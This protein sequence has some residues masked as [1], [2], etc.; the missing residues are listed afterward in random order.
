MKKMSYFGKTIFLTVLLT[1]ILNLALKTDSSYFLVGVLFL[2]V[3]FFS[4]MSVG[5]QSFMLARL[6]FLFVNGAILFVL[7]SQSSISDNLFLEISSM[8]I[9][10]VFLAMGRFSSL[11]KMLP[12]MSR[13]DYGKIAPKYRSRR[14]IILSFLYVTAFVWYANAFIVYSLWGYSFSAALILVFLVTFLLTSFTMK[15]YSASGKERKSAAP[16]PIYSW[17]IGLVIGQISW[18][19]GF[20]PFGYL[21]VAFI[22]TIIYYTTSMILRDYLFRRLE[23]RSVVRELIFAG[24]IIII[25]FYFTNWLPL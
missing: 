14:N 4:S 12:N 1:A 11:F 16:L 10:S 3:S 23:P 7:L 25:T 21:T 5:A 17:I 18:V 22:I 9:F 20:W 8:I 24:L 6:P 19:V 13:E 2:V 15:I